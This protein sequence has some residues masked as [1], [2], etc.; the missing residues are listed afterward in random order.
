MKDNQVLNDTDDPRSC[1]CFLLSR[2]A[3]AAQKHLRV[4]L[5]PYGLTPAQYLIIECLW[6]SDRMSPKVIGELLRFDSATLTG[7]VDRLERAGFVYRQPDPG[8]RRAIRICL[9]D[10]SRGMKTELRALRLRANEEILK[11]F[12]R[13]QRGIFK[14]ALM[15]LIAA[16][17]VSAA[18]GQQASGA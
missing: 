10:K 4:A 15:S 8:D 2:A 14:Q 11:V 13:Q 18:D 17:D 3:Q 7:L 1:V 12:P 16:E 9:T 5:E 6:L